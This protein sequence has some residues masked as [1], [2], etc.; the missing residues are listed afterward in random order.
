MK[1]EEFALEPGERVLL[2]IRRHWVVFALELLPFLIAAL[3][4]F[5]IPL[6]FGTLGER[7]QD[8]DVSFSLSE[9][10][11][12]LALGIWWLMVWA[13]AFA[14]FTRS[15]LDLWVVTT[16]RIANIRQE[17]FFDRRVES[18]LLA[19]VQDV[20]TEVSGIIATLFGIGSVR[21][22]TA[23]NASRTFRMHGLPDPEAVRDLVI[24]EVARINEAGTRQVP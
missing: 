1:L 6:L 20:T 8:L 10:V 9:P 18:F 11:V 24:R 15:Y 16:T 7:F 2:E 21:V 22:E 17:G 4:P 5:L 3:I 13:S 14:T 19:R 12:R 23:G